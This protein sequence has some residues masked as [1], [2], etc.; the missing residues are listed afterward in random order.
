MH[1]PYQPNANLSIESVPQREGRE[2]LRLMS[3]SVTDTYTVRLAQ[4]VDI[5]GSLV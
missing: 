3:T 4:H 1:G 5:F 2:L